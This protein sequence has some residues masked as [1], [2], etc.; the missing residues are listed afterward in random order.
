MISESKPFRGVA[1]NRKFQEGLI[2]QK[3]LGP[4]SIEIRPLI[5]VIVLLDEKNAQYFKKMML[6]SLKSLV[7]AANF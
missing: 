6:P 7:N 2:R 5:S 3:C 4:Q 1:I